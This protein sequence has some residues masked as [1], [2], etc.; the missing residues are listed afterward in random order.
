MPEEILNQ[1]N[2]PG[3]YVVISGIIGGLVAILVLFLS[4]FF[5]W[6]EKPRITKKNVQ[7]EALKIKHLKL[8]ELKI[9]TY[10]NTTNRI[11][12]IL[13]NFDFHEDLSQENMNDEQRKFWHQR[14]KQFHKEKNTIISNLSLIAPTEVVDSTKD[15][16]E[17]L[18]QIIDDQK[19]WD[20]PMI[21]NKIQNLLNK[22][23]AD[24]DIDLTPIDFKNHP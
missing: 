5:D 22:M 23:R 11:A 15:L 2:M 20:W 19:D 18:R 9:D 6:F 3:I 13:A 4:R 17:Y 8:Y 10:K 1:V 7:F 14:Y 16:F 21:I 24:I 12:T